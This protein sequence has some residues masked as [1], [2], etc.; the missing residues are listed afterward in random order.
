M[1]K[2]ASLSILAAALAF[3]LAA[4]GTP[5]APVSSV[6]DVHTPAVGPGLTT[7]ALSDWSA[8]GDLTVEV[9]G[10]GLGN[11]NS[12]LNNA[13]I[14]IPNPENVVKVYV[15]V[16][17]KAG[18]S[19]EG[20]YPDPESVQIIAYDAVAAEI[21]NKTFTDDAVANDT[22][23]RVD[24]ASE[25]GGSGTT[26]WSHETDFVGEVAE[27]EVNISANATAAFPNSPRA[28]I[29]SVFRDLGDGTS[30]AG[31]VPNLYVFGLDG[32]PTGERTIGL[33]ADFAGGNVTVTFAI[34]DLELLSSASNFTAN[35]P[36]IIRYS[37]SAGGVDAN[38]E[39]DM[40]NEG[41]DLAI[42]QLVLP[43]VPASAT[44]LTAQVYSP[45]PDDATPHGDSV[46]FNTVS[47]TVET[48]E[49]GGTE[50][51]TPG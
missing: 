34:S 51:C 14:V 5:L 19:G 18:T 21:G 37:A 42:V 12:G 39:I 31:A 46:Y 26:G 32:Y 6:D 20:T 29:V 25:G 2:L 3:L 16:V 7:S 13:T 44:E 43:N 17:T 38:D 24:I 40:P 10:D 4:C 11:S 23:D 36:R 28:L 1:R 47:V 33:P 30:S 48:A 41:A 49:E 22:V 35:D 45:H 27:V 9:I 15:Q 50:G 8:D